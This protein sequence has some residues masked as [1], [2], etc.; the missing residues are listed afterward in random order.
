MAEPLGK[1]YDA[2]AARIDPWMAVLALVF[3][4][5]WSARII[6]FHSLPSELR[7]TMLVVQWWIWL[8][9]LADIVIRTVISNRSWRYLWTHPLDVIAVAV[10][11]ARPLKLLTAFTQGAAF[12][13]ARGRM[14]TM[15]AVVVSVVL[16]LWIG[17]V[18]VLAAEREVAD[19]AINSFGDALWWAVVTVT[20]VGYGDFAPVS[21]TGRVIAVVMMLLGIALI[22]VVTA[23]VAAWFVSRTTGEDERQQELQDEG[24]HDELTERIARLEAKIDALAGSERQPAREDDGTGARG[25]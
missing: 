20:T 3:L 23:S 24:R 15:Q 2:Y 12:S 13:S 14:K 21:P 6:F 19:S 7:A 1:R 16:L 11:A 10:P 18:A 9:F 5:V 4:V 8:V 22:G 17:S 25:T